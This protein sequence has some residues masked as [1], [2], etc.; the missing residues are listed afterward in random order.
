MGCGNAAADTQ[1][2]CVVIRGV[3]DEEVHDFVELT[4]HLP[5]DVRFIEYM[6]FDENAWA[7]KKFVSYR[8]MLASIQAR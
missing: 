8:E 5:I 2:N 6:P 4:R 3:N 7:D 1:V